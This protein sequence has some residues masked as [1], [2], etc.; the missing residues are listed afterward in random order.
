MG[1]YFAYPFKPSTQ[2]TLVTHSAGKRFFI[3]DNCAAVRGAISLWKPEPD[4]FLLAAFIGLE[5]SMGM[6]AASMKGSTLSQMLLM[7]MASKRIPQR[8]ERILFVLVT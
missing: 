6:Q 8:S 2:F 5:H 4:I 7:E 3:L 1:L